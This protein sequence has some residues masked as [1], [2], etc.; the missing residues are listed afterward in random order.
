MKKHH[1]GSE[2]FQL[3]NRKKFDALVTKW[4]MDK[5]VRNF[6]TWEM[7]QVLI[8]CMVMRLG[9][10]SEIESNFKIPDSTF[11]DALRERS[12]NFFQDLCG[13]ILD[14]I[15]GRTKNR[16]IRKAIKELVAIDSTEIKVHGSLFNEPGWQQKHVNGEHKASAKLHVVWNINGEWIEDFR[17]TPGRKGDSPVSLQFRLLPGKIYIFDRAYNDFNFWNKIVTLGSHFVSR[18]KDYTRW[19]YLEMQATQASEAKTG[20]LYDGEHESQ[21]L[22]SKNSEIK[23]RHIIYKDA[24]SNKVFHFVTSNFRM[25]AKTIAEIYKRRWAVELLFR[26]LKSHLDIRR[27]PTKTPNAIKTQ[28]AVVVLVQLLL[29]LKKIVD[30]FKG[31]LWELLRALRAQLNWD[32]IAGSTSPPD[33]RWSSAAGAGL[34]T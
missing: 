12:F 20:V 8:N 24:E 21:S 3:I 32:G 26:W 16:R 10:Y 11:G 22:K 1:K 28:I 18:L 25:S 5:S 15:H 27:L 17:I 31:T 13:L 19:R 6:K 34:K 4:D 2:L 33:C 7:T 9:S 30:Q 23:L 29:Q 14:E